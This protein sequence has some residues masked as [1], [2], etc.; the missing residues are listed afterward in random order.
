MSKEKIE[1]S[2]FAR[3]IRKF[4]PG[5]LQ[6]DDEII[7]QFVARRHEFELVREVLDNNISAPS[8][9]HVLVVAPRGHGK[10]MLLARVAAEVR[11]DEELEQHLIP[12]R[13]MEESQ[14][15]DGLAD[16][17]LETLYQLAREL[18]DKHH[19]MA[20]ELKKT[21]ADLSMRWREQGI[22]GL[23]QAAVLDA[24]DRL[25]Q[26]LVLL[27]ENMQSLL[28]NMDE[29]FGW[30]LRSALQSLPQIILVASATSRFE[31]L[32]DPSAPFF[33]LFHCVYLKALSPSEC[34]RLWT[35]I[36]GQSP[37]IHEIRPL[38]ILTGGN[39]RLLVM[40]ASFARHWS[41]RRLM[42]E[43]VSLIDENTDY[44]RGNLESLPT[45]ERRVFVSLI[46]LWQA[47]NAG[48][49]AARARLDVRT[50]STMLGRLVE[51]GAVTVVSDSKGGK[52]LY[53][54]AER[55]YS[56]YYKLRRERDEA[57]V[58]EALIHFMVAFYDVG[59]VYQ[60][61]DLLMKETLE[62]SAIQE[63]I[64][65]ALASRTLSQDGKLDLKWDEVARVSDE[66]KNRRYS[67]AVVKLQ[68]DVHDAYSNANWEFLLEIVD[69]FE[70]DPLSD[71]HWDWESDR[72]RAVHLAHL[73]SDAYLHLNKHLQVIEVAGDVV[74]SLRGTEDTTLISKAYSMGLNVAKAYY[75]LGDFRR[76]RMECDLLLEYYE[77][78]ESP[79]YDPQL[80]SALVVKAESETGL[81]NDERAT[82]L[83]DK[84][85]ERFGHSDALDVQRLVARSMVGHGETAQIQYNRHHRAIETYSKTISH[86]GGSDDIEIRILVK[87]AWLNKGIA[88]GMLGD[89]E[90]EIA[91][92]EEL[93]AWIEKRNAPY[94]RPSALT[95]L[96][97]KSRRLAELG[98]AEEAL[99]SSKDS[100]KRLDMCGSIF[101]ANIRQWI[102]WY[103]R[104]TQALAL[105]A[106]GKSDIAMDSF[107]CAYYSFD[108]CDDSHVGEMLRLVP[109]LISAGASERELVDVLQSDTRRAQSLF[110]MIVA[111]QQRQGES[112][113]APEEILGVAEDFRSFVSKRKEEGLMPGFMFRMDL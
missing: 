109:E 83:L 30:K 61:S 40:V 89:F 63:G 17:W 112:V 19:A 91:C 59:E 68:E 76:S 43:L 87:S 42:E 92:Y 54:A 96:I 105:V 55:L 33:E 12:V 64:D 53:A 79:C 84:V 15:I 57:A 52:R 82:N 86:F 100:A 46:D 93:V 5:L 49:I 85:L 103:M 47:S 70:A 73:R 102:A 72:A 111:L 24:A 74:E 36:T 6:S 44:F 98:R 22:E 99:A 2:A 8:C 58:V 35:E 13:F 4:N 29:E 65:R 39:P 66:V 11:R 18:S 3:P 56:I 1:D 25:N 62:S 34:L 26:R 51:R 20:Q 110:P 50:V 113:R 14:E 32:K 28:S 67:A 31:E 107:R 94:D 80:V 41:I 78:C 48:E 75:H 71:F 9:Q 23:A 21:H 7:S 38:Q 37:H 101:E 90:S 69:Q 77:N 95:A 81:G 27:V 97:Y 104:G 88:H 45:K 16:F 106:I 108:P 10:T 60:V